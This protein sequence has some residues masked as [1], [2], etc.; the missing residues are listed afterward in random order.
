MRLIHEANDFFRSKNPLIR[1][2]AS[3]LLNEFRSLYESEAFHFGGHYWPVKRGVSFQLSGY[4]Y[5]QIDTS[6]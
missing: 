1:R 5:V 6:P 3:G 2:M 4:K